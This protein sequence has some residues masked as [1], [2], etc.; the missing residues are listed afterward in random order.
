MIIP[1]PTLQSQFFLFAN[2]FK[3]KNVLYESYCYIAGILTMSII[4]YFSGDIN[5]S[6]FIS[7]VAMLLF[8]TISLKGDN[9]R[10]YIS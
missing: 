10:N 9:E 5:L 2:F 1:L 6:I 3:F 8:S 4:L 7:S